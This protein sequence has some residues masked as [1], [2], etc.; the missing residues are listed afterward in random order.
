MLT[1]AG[2]GIVAAILLVGVYLISLHH[3][4]DQA[5]NPRAAAMP[6]NGAVVV[7]VAI[8]EAKDCSTRAEARGRRRRLFMLA[9][10][11]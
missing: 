4:P 11:A 2:I 3:A 1:G 10:C 6:D 7:R 8:T 5:A 9:A